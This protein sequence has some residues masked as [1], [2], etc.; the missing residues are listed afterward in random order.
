MSG[1]MQNSDMRYFRMLLLMVALLIITHQANAQEWKS[2]TEFSNFEKYSE[3]NTVV[4]PP[5]DDENRVVF[6]GN[7][8]TESWVY[9]RPDFFK[10]SNYIGR[11]ISGQ[12]TPQMLLRFRRDVIGLQPKV[13]VILAGINDIAGNTGY[14]SIDL[15]AENIMTMSDIA[16]SHGMRVIICSVTPAIGFPWSPKQEPVDLIIELNTLL[17]EYADKNNIAYV[18]YHTALKDEKN[19]LKV[20]EY[21]TAEDLVHPNKAGYLVMESLIQ[22]AIE[23]ELSYTSLSVNPFFSDHMVLQRNED[24]TVWGKAPKGQQ[25]KV[26]GS[27]GEESTATADKS[28]HWELPLKTPEAGGPFNISITSESSSIQVTDVMIGEVWLASGQSNMAMPLKGWPPN[29]PIKNSEEEIANANYPRIRMFKVANKF[30]LKEEDS[31]EGKWDVCTPEH[32]SEYSASAYFFARRLHKDL[33][34]PIGIIHSSWGGTPAEAWVS[35]N[36]IKK[37]GDFDELVRI[38]ENPETERKTREWFDRWEK[39]PVPT[40]N[41]GWNQIDLK[42][43]YIAAPDYETKNWSTMQLPGRLDMYNDV[44]I[45]GAFWFRKE[46]VLDDISSNYTFEM[47][48]SD[49]TDV[50]FIN[51]EKIGGTAYEFSTTRTYPVPSSLLQKGKNTIA[52]R[53]IDTGGPGSINGDIKLKTQNGEELSL[54]GNWD[55]AITGE[56]H[57]SY[58]YHYSLDKIDLDER[59][60]VVYVSPYSTPSSLYNAMIHPL[61]SFKI[62]GAIW[63]QGESNV[64][65]SEQYRRLFPEL[66]NDWRSQWKDDFPFYFVQIAPFKYNSSDDHNLDKSQELRDAQ[67][68][69]LSLDKTGMVVTLD[70]GNNENIHPAN[71]QDV[72]Q[73]LAGLALVNDYGKGKVAS[74][75]LYKRIVVKGKKVI[76]EFDHVGQ[77]LKSFDEELKGFEIAG[78]DLKY[79][80]ADAKIVKNKVR[81]CSPKI[82]DPKYVRY[83]WRDTSVGTLFNIEGLPASSFTTEK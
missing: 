22:P 80:P 31:F 63:Y 8:I 38:L 72:G 81:V 64:G 36:R 71:K 19:G 35:E 13:V 7:S 15:I 56:I 59:P 11:G 82:S 68:H 9:F 26:V 5:T 67:R 30:S 61:T 65:R 55:Y 6:M 52:I 75:P 1:L 28:G 73:R 77:G 27:W 12:T 37:L 79:V 17:K 16:K 2:Y 41:E 43:D 57:N 54:N 14:T 58:F 48:F 20:P 45:D 83:A 10:D 29:D 4:L 34:I 50:V 32:A 53:I 69:T 25:V 62:K 24:I 3:D 70:I 78:A 60:N 76:L 46:I 42:D 49:D 44:D 66:I 47:G 23:K 33:N 39:T 18:D 21:T 74:G 51:G 40:E